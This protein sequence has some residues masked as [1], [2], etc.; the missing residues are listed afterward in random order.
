M[1]QYAGSNLDRWGVQKLYQ[2]NE[3]VTAV[4]IFNVASYLAHRDIILDI[5]GLGCIKVDVSY[6]ATMRWMESEAE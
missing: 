1:S 4:K 5:P 3:K 6:G 2:K